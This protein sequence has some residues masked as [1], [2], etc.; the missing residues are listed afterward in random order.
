[1][2]VNWPVKPHEF[3]RFLLQRFYQ[4]D[5]MKQI[6]TDESVESG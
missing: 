6:T 2:P 5:M 1:M 4:L 3:T